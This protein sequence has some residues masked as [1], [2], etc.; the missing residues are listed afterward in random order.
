MELVY[1]VIGLALVEFMVFAA[2][3][4]RARVQQKVMAPATSGNEI[5]ERYHRSH[6]NTMEQLVVFIP[7]ILMFGTYISAAWAAGIG[8]VFLI[9]RILY[10]RAYVQDPPKRTLGFMLSWLPNIALLLGGIGGLIWQMT[11]S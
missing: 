11:A 7:A 2:F 9:G 5:F 4:G 1:L 8:A 10:I 6:Y 3:V